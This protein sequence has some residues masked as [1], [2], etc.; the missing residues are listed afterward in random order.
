[1]SCF[2]LWVRCSAF[3]CRNERCP[4][5]STHSGKNVIQSSASSNFPSRALEFCFVVMNDAAFGR[6]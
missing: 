1:M 3:K 2:C 4:G 6:V 5:L